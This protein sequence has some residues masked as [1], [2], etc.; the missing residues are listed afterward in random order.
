MHTF[1]LFLRKHTGLFLLLGMLMNGGDVMGQFNINASNTNY[2]E[3]FNSL[4][5]T[6]WTNNSTL[7]GWYARTDATT[8]ISAYALN[9]GTTTT[10]GLYS[11]GVAGTNLLSDKSIGFAPT[12][13]YF[14]SAGSGK[15]YIGWR[16]KNN[17]GANITSITVTWTGEQWRRDN[18]VSQNLTFDYQK[19]TAVADLMLGTWTNVPALTFASPNII[20]LAR[21]LDGN[22]PENRIQNISATITVSVLPGE[23][24]MLRWVD[25]NDSGNDHYLTVDDVTI[26]A[27]TET[28][29]TPPTVTALSPTDDAPNVAVNSNLGITFNESIVKGTGNILIKRLSD[30]STFETIDVTSAAVTIST[31]TVTIDPTSNFLNST[32]YYVEIP[33]TAFRDAANNFYA[34]I[35]GATAW[36]FT[37]GAT[38]ITS[39]IGGNWSNPATWVGGVVPTSAD[40]VVIAA[41]HTVFLNTTTNGINVRNAGTTTVVNSL[42]TLSTLVEYIN[43]GATTINGTFTLLSGG[44]ATGQP[45]AYA[46]LAQLRLSTGSAITMNNTD[47]YWSAS[48]LESPFID[49]NANTHLTL[50]TGVN[51]VISSNKILILFGQISFP[52]ATLTVN[53]TLRIRDAAAKVNHS[54]IYGAGSSLVY[55]TG[56]VYNRGAEWLPGAGVVNVTA[57]HPQDLYI[58]TNTQLNLPNGIDD[59]F[60]IN[61]FID[62]AGGA[63]LLQ[64]FDGTSASLNVRGSI[65]IAGTLLLGNT[66]GRD[67]AIGGDWIQQATSTF[68][69]NGRAVIFNGATTQTIRKNGGD[70]IV[71]F[72]Y[73]VIDK[74]STDVR[75]NTTT[76]VVI[77]GA[78]ASS[79]PLE[80]KNAGTL[81][82]NGRTLTLNNNGGDI[83]VT[84]LNTQLKSTLPNANLIINGTKKVE[85]AGTLII[86]A[87][88]RTQLNNGFNVGLNK[89][90]FNG[91]CQINASGF[92][93]NSPFYGPSSTLIYN[94]G[95]EY[96]RSAEWNATSGAGYPNAVQISNNTTLNY[97]N[98]G[99]GAFSTNL[100]IAK[101]LT[102]DSGSSLFMGFGDNGNKSG[103]LTVGG[104]L[105]NNGNLGLGNATGGDLRLGGNFASNGTFI[106]NNRRVF[107]IKNGLQTISSTNTNPLLTLPYVVLEAASGN[108]IVQLNCDLVISAPLGGN[109]ILFDSPTS[110]NDVIDLFGRTLTI[111]TNG[112]NNTIGGSG[113]FK[114]SNA[115]SLILLGSGNIG[116]LRFSSDL[117]LQNLTLEK[118]NNNIGFELGTNLTIV[119]IL[120]LIDGVIEVGNGSELRIGALGSIVGFDNTDFIIANSGRLR[121]NFSDGTGV[122]RSFT[123]PIGTSIGSYTPATIDIST[124]NFSTSTTPYL[125]LNVANVK[126]PNNVSPTHFI[127]RYW[128]VQGDG[129]TN[130]TYSFVGDFLPGDIPVGANIT[131]M[132]SGRYRLNPVPGYWIQSATNL[133]ENKVAISNITTNVDGAFS[134]TGG[135]NFTAGNP[136]SVAEIN[137]RPNVVPVVTSIASGGIFDFGTRPL[138]SSTSVTFTIENLGLET[139]NLGAATLTNSNAANYSLTQNYTATVNGNGTTTFDITFAPTLL[140]TITGSISI[141]NSDVSGSENP[142]V[143]NFTGIG[144]YSNLS[145]IIT[146][147]GEPNTISSLVNTPTINTATD[148]VEVWQFTIRDGG[149][150]LNDLDIAPT[151]INTL[152]ITQGVGNQINDWADAI[153]AVAL[154]NGSTKI[155]D[156]AVTGT[157]IV[158]TG[159]PLVTV[160]DNQSMTLSLRLSIETNPN[161]TGGNLDND[162]FQFSITNANTAIASGSQF[163]SSFPVATSTNDLNRLSVVATQLSFVQQPTTTGINTAMTPAVT[164][165]ATDING[166]RDLDY[167]ASVAITSTGTLTGTPVNANTVVAGLATFSTLTHSVAGTGFTLTA[168]S[169]GLIN[170]TSNP[171]NITNIVYVNGDW[172]SMSDGNWFANSNETVIWYRRIGGNWV[173][174]SAGTFPSGTS[175]LYTVY[176]DKNIN[177]AVAASNYATGKIHILSGGKIVYLKSGTPWTFRNII[178]DNGGTLQAETR[179]QVNAG[180]NFEIKDGGN[181]IYNHSANTLTNSTGFFLAGTENFHSNSNFIIKNLGGGS[182]LTANIM[183]SITA[184]SQNAYF[185]NLIV[186]YSGGENNFT[187]ITSGTYTNSNFQ[188][189]ICN[190]LIFR[191]NNNQPPRIYQATT[192][193]I[194]SSNPLTIQ[195]NLQIENT[196]TQTISFTTALQSAGSYY[197]NIKKDFIHNGTAT[198]FN[199]NSNT[200]NSAL[201]YFIVEGNVSLGAGAK[202]VF[203]TAQSSLA[204]MFLQIKGNLTVASSGELSDLGTDPGTFGNV[205]FN[206]T[207]GVQLI[208][209][210]NQNT[211]IKVNYSVRSSSEAKLINQN[212]TLGSSSKLTVENGGTF[213]F[214][215]NGSNALFVSGP[216]FEANPGSTL[217][218]TS[219]DGI[220]AFGAAGNVRTSTRVFAATTPFGNYQYIGKT[221]QSTGNALPVTVNNLTLN[222]ETLTNNL[223]LSQAVKV[224]G[225]LAMV[226]GNI[227]STTTNLLEIGTSAAAK[228]SLTYTNGFVKGPMKRWFSGVNSGIASGLFPLGTLDNKN[229]FAQIEYTSDPTAGALTAQLQG[230]MGVLGLMPPPEIPVTGICPMFNVL[231][232]DNMYWS[233]T[234]SDNLANGLYDATITK[235]N[236]SAAESDICKQTILT[237]TTLSWGVLGTHEA[238][239]GTPTNITL[240]RT[241]INTIKDLGIG[242]GY[243]GTITKIYDQASD[244]TATPPTI[245]DRIQV[246]ANYTIP[247][248]TVVS[249][250]ECTVSSNTTLTI[251]GNASLAVVEGITVDTGSLID[252]NNNGSLVQYRNVDNATANNNSGNI[253][254]ERITKPLFRFD[255]T[256]WSSPVQDFVLKSVSPTTLFDKF[257]S[258]NEVGQAWLMHPSNVAEPSLERMAPGRG[259]IVRAPQGFPIETPTATALFHT[260]NFVGKP[261]NGTVTMNVAG[262]PDPFP[263]VPTT[264]YKWNL[265][266]NP[267]PSAIDA[268]TF[269]N[270][271]TNLGGTLYFWTHNTSIS[272][273]S[274]SYAPNDYASWNGTGATATLAGADGVINNNAPTGKIAAGQGFFVK[275]IADGTGIATFNNTMRVRE[276]GENNQFFKGFIVEEHTTNTTPSEKHRVWLNIKGTPKGFNQLLVGYI[277]NAT[278]DYDNRFDGE[279]FGGNLVTFYSINNTKNLVIQGRALPFINTDTVPLGYKTTLTGN[280]TI[281]I[282]HVDGLMEDQDIYLQDNVLNVVHD[283]KA[284]NYTFATVPGTFNSR[285][286][287]RYLPQED[288]SNPSFDDQLKAV[289]I[290]KNEATLYVSSP[291]ETIA[292]VAVYDLTGRLVFERKNCNTNRFET[293]ELL[294]VDQALI[295]KVTLMNG[296]VVTEK[297]AP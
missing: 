136:F 234:A 2:S 224:Q 235:E 38:T 3:N 194:D 44:G 270:A 282:D 108:P 188:K 30:N 132:K 51:R 265:L 152:T 37:T 135:Y 214:G 240:K 203:R 201:Y 204:S 172:L 206:G 213:D 148:G 293:T 43:N 133:T 86:N 54:P 69:P 279:S 267:Y 84:N 150:S 149:A 223:T 73:L 283:L 280:L 34:G 161:N 27:A 286:V 221:N 129:I 26:N 7:T 253:K 134:S 105:L 47:A 176:I 287:L 23:E 184:N 268:T 96:G 222:N 232:T 281:S 215:F 259:Y 169:S 273:A 1:L 21:A 157:Q 183:N 210:V 59:T 200:N 40:N 145:D 103:S 231:S 110:A 209:F 269:L 285:F 131:S 100:V 186:D 18:T 185:G 229:R 48:L 126:E 139:L 263:V 289:R 237:G 291:Y 163:N 140:G 25:L 91:I 24:I 207:T 4:T 189:A 92:F 199:L 71:T 116:T 130:A 197:L 41:G 19:G 274:P 83:W 212:F 61:G 211:N 216:S 297:V 292:T 36:N 64:F 276:A 162:D 249:A 244:W 80:I 275:G 250:C 220:V 195:G 72:D 89:T 192:S 230:T 15:G 45:F 239:T 102:I 94:T 58:S 8:L 112:L 10:A 238:S 111:G 171:F 296:A 141:P 258:W 147:G 262:Q 179:F 198:F 295:V 156:G 117:S 66:I 33:N 63:S 35:T 256:Y 104:D 99:G 62:I 236:D 124:G 31:N 260:A 20:G 70:G 68:T 77:N 82:L 191:T 42:G 128:N 153:Q 97:P 120:N 242:K 88:I 202:Y 56:A 233:M 81:D 193:Y 241:G 50:N 251:A 294:S 277:E 121:K 218:I 284:S 187:L 55:D 182:F 167:T 98:T 174:Q 181:F 278:N 255:Y 160:P 266:G 261:N 264:V 32:G 28:D 257:F 107:F 170:A 243:C 6:T 196:F 9:T 226:S 46:P 65:N 271:N 142:Y 13:T 158:F 138:G 175:D 122:S 208:D 57:G 173:E 168:A 12:N 254:M 227:I 114:G 125:S 178:I 245:L 78:A 113:T 109:A 155:A 74:A 52:N 144:G 11:F 90:T 252:I 123:F 246:T 29:T 272:S 143:I 166:N 247:A 75:I 154:F 85:G 16:L 146:A 217:K 165:Q 288:L 180:G 164:V 60:Y 101:N 14:G 67:I 225:A 76:N 190:D 119:G 127:N 39:A 115:S 248:N 87:D 118:Q 53:G 17:T 93:S 151:I 5:G 106:A 290:Y 177:V 159:A 228:G 137:I 205:W 219:A 95:G 79:R 49:I 22:A